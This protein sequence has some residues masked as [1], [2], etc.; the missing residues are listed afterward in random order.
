MIKTQK[1]GINVLRMIVCLILGAI[2][3]LICAWGTSTAP[4]SKSILTIGFLIYIWYNRLIL[5]FIIGYADKIKIIKHELGNSI[6]RGAILGAILSV[7]LIVIPGLAAVSY[8]Y[9]GIIYG[10]IIDLIATKFAPTK[11]EQ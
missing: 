3:G 7:I 5:G 4:I 9:A 10:I 1:F 2:A 8:L 6:V 11:S